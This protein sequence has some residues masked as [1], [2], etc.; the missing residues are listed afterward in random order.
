MKSQIYIHLSDD[1]VH[2]IVGKDYQTIKHIL[3]TNVYCPHSDSHRVS[4][5]NVKD[6]ILN[7]INDIVF[8]GTCIKCGN[9]VARYIETGENSEYVK[10]IEKLLTERKN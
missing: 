6:I 2:Y 10:R 1:D 3:K 7:D 8:H 4:G 9:K 5:M